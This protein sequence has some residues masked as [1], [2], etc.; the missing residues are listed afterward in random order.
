LKAIL[1]ELA[2]VACALAVVGAAAGPGHDK[3]VLVPPPEAAA[4]NFLRALTEH[5]WAQA[6]GHLAADLRRTAPSELAALE[7]SLE[8]T[9]GSVENVEGED[10]VLAGETATARASIDFSTARVELHLPFRRQNGLWK[11]ASL[12]P[13]RHLGARR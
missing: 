10:A 8:K 5:R 3:G 13:L 12:D 1:A 6:R 7:T 11:V 2:A 9:R 4:E